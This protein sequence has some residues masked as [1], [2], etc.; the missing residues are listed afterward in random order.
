VK[1]VDFRQKYVATTNMKIILDKCNNKVYIVA[2]MYVDSATIK[3]KDKTYTRYLLRTS[4]RDS[5]K[6]KHR[7]S[8]TAN[9]HINIT[10]PAAPF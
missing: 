7:F 9:R 3:R 1:M 5:G 8:Q 4:Y 10:F 6:V 2:T